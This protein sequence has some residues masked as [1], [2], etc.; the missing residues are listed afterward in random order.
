MH[1]ERERER[2]R[3]TCDKWSPNAVAS[4]AWVS[5]RQG[6]ATGSAATSFETCL[7]RTDSS[8]KLVMARFT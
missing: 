4:G 3:E 5:G 6:S 7:Q 8:H 2:Q 1:R